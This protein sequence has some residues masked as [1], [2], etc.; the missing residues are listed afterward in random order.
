MP[1]ATACA[2]SQPRSGP[3]FD[4]VNDAA[5]AYSPLWLGLARGWATEFAT[6]PTISD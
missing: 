3:G 6:D 1:V 5:D 4:G 2:G